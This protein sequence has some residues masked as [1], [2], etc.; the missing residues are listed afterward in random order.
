MSLAISTF[1]NKSRSGDPLFKALG[2]PAVAKRIK[3]WIEDMGKRG[4]LAVVDPWGQFS[5][6]DALYDLSALTVSARYVQRIEDLP[7]NQNGGVPVLLLSELAHTNAGAVMLAAFDADHARR[8]LMPLIADRLPVFSFD[9]LK[10]EEQYLTNKRRYLDPL[11]FATNYALFRAG[12]GRHSVVRTA[13]Y[14]SGYGA[15]APRAVADPAFRRG[16]GPC[17]LG[18]ATRQGPI[19]RTRCGG[20]AP[21]AI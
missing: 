15:A 11:N 8:A 19:D 10:L 20:G 3:A 4:A 5:C 1:D 14:W 2:H 21:A 17:Q 12:N 6:L 13:E 18:R 9:D 7:A 16:R